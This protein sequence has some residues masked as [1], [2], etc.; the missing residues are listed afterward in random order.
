MKIIKPYSFILFIGTLLFSACTTQPQKPAPEKKK[1]AITIALMPYKNFDTSLISFIKTEITGFYINCDV[2]VL[3]E[4]DLP[5]FAFYKP[6]QRYKADSLLL[7]QK[8]F[9]TGDVRTVVGLTAS[10]ISTTHSTSAYWGVFGL[11]YCPGKAAVIST[12]RLKKS[13][14][15]LQ[16]FKQR[17]AKVILHELGHNF[18]LPHC[19]KD[20]ACLMNDAIGQIKQVDKEKI[21]L[22][23]SCKKLLA[24]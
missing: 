19:D 5:A 12:Y 9:N 17:L 13:S 14:A 18:G 6:R 3:P 22:C 2:I 4:K 7:Y 1:K 11:G 24:R 16:Q 21:W 8:Q 20:K 15:S 23:D 10:D